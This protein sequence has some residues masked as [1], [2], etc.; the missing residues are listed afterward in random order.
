[1]IPAKAQFEDVR[2]DE[3]PIGDVIARVRQIHKLF[4]KKAN[5][6]KGLKK[7]NLNVL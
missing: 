4:D 1:V 5:N 3:I 2:V 7:D 6:K